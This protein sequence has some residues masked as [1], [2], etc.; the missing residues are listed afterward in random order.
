MTNKKL[1]VAKVK[2]EAS[3]LNKMKSVTIQ[4]DSGATYTLDIKEKITPTQIDLAF[5][6]VVEYLKAIM[7]RDD[8]DNA[9]VAQTTSL[10]M[11]LSFVEQVT[12]LELPKTI[13]E[14]LAVLSNFY[15][16]GIIP[17]ILEKLD[18]KEVE[19][20]TKKLE[21]MINQFTAEIDKATEELM[22]S[23]EEQSRREQVLW[24]ADEKIA[25][26]NELSYDDSEMI[27]DSEALDENKVIP[28]KKA[29]D[30]NGSE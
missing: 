1:T 13:E 17:K 16:L 30:I 27:K 25:Q 10:Y 18:E 22:R 26:I 3:K 28:M 29:N 20:A 11:L 21:E 14:R 19:K 8:L 12:S 9:G 15:D 6:S 2:Q 23:A 24:E 7:D 4:L 5:G